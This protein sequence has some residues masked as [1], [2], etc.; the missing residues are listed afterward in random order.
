MDIERIRQIIIEE[1][2]KLMEAPAYDTDKEKLA[3]EKDVTSQNKADFKQQ[4]LDFNKKKFDYTQDKDYE[5]EQEKEEQPQQGEQDQAEPE[6][7]PN[8]S[9]KTQGQFYEEAYPE[10]RNLVL[11]NGNL[12]DEDE[13]KYIALAVQAAEGR[14]DKGFDRFL[15]KGRAGNVYGKDF[16]EDD[17]SKII[18]YCRF[19]ELVR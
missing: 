6:K 4:K 2:N 7:K 5:K 17:I 8:I 18:K 9:F 10:L 14:V 13:R 16:S 12:I 1:I 3:K 19:H 15:R 11:S